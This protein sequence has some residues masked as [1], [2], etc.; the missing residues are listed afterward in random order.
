[1]LKSATRQASESQD[2]ITSA[3]INSL[4]LIIDGHNIAIIVKVEEPVLV[5]VRQLTPNTLL[6]LYLRDVDGHFARPLVRVLLANSIHDFSIDSD[7][8]IEEA[9]RHDHKIALEQR[10]Q[11]LDAAFDQYLGV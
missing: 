7:L 6:L 5:H 9:R 11:L 2:E 3:S 10:L 8:R 1:V 4:A